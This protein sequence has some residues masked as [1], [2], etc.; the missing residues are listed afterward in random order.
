MKKDTSWLT[1]N[2][3]LVK[4]SDK[5]DANLVLNTTNVVFA[6]M[7]TI[8]L[9]LGVLLVKNNVELVVQVILVILVNTKIQTWMIIVTPV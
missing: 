6:K 3:F 1:P 4:S 2:V 5:K 9:V 8:R 7:D